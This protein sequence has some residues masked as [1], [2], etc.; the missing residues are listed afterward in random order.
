MENLQQPP[1][2]NK[3]NLWTWAP[4]I[5][6]VLYIAFISLFAL[7]VFSEGYGLA[8][9]TLALFMHLL[10]SLALV[11]ALIVAWRK[12]FIGGIVFILIGAF[13]L[14]AFDAYE[15]LVNFLLIPLPPIVAGI[16]FVIS[17]K[18]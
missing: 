1:A 8:E 17:G 9:A 6:T 15:N 14:V 4:R 18:K 5:L 3:K 2:Q 13:F 12:K 11:I 7:D 16:L 10:P